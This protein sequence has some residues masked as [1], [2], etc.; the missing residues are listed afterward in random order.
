MRFF[1][2]NP[3]KDDSEERE[4]SFWEGRKKYAA[5]AGVGFVLILAGRA[6]NGHKQATLDQ[7]A[8]AQDAQALQSQLQDAQALAQRLQQEHDNEAAKALYTASGWRR[9]AFDQH[10]LV[11]A[12]S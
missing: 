8:N 5:I 1:G 11:V 12:H 10:E 7:L 4:P 2:K 6:C 3:P 9:M